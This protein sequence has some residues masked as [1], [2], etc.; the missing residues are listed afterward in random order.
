MVIDAEYYSRLA[1]WTWGKWFN[2]RAIGGYKGF[3][4]IE[5]AKDDPSTLEFSFSTIR[6]E[7]DI[8]FRETGTY[9]LHLRTHATDHTMNGF[10]AAMDGW[11][12]DYGHPQAY[13]IFV[14]QSSTL[15]AGDGIQ[16]AVGQE[17]V[18]TRS[19]STSPGK[20]SRHWLFSGETRGLAL[21]V[22]G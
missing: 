6:A 5:A 1:G 11:K 16:T 3:G 21:I 17:R 13:Y 14:Q 12:F 22:Y 8:D 7:Y 10:F 15:P 4:Y 18:A 2:N 19:A 9:Y 20:V